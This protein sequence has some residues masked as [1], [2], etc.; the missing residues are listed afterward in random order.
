MS[1]ITAKAKEYL[2]A[3]LSVIPAKRIKDQLYL[4]GYHTRARD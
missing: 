2:E 3:Q 4:L 1:N